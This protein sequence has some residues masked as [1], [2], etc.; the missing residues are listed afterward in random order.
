MQC[1]P[2][3]QARVFEVER[4][5]RDP[6]CASGLTMGL[7]TARVAMHISG[8]DPVTLWISSQFFARTT[9]SL[10]ELACTLRNQRGA[11]QWAYTEDPS[12]ADLVFVDADHPSMEA[13][14]ANV[15]A[16]DS[17]T[18]RCSREVSTDLERGLL[19]KPLRTARIVEVM[20]HREAALLSTRAA[21]SGAE[22]VPSHPEATGGAGSQAALERLGHLRVSRNGGGDD[23]VPRTLH[24]LEWGDGSAASILEL[25]WGSA[26]VS[27]DRATLNVWGDLQTLQALLLSPATQVTLRSQGAATGASSGVNGAGVVTNA[28][29]RGSMGRPHDRLPRDRTVRLR[30]WPQQPELVATRDRIAA[31]QRL[32]R[33][34]ILEEIL[35]GV[36]KETATWELE[37]LVGVLNACWQLGYLEAAEASRPAG[38]QPATRSRTSAP[39]AEGLFGRI[40]QRLGL[41]NP[42]THRP[43]PPNRPRQATES[44]ANRSR[45]SPV[46]MGPAEVSSGNPL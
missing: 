44:Q 25:R 37:C 22:A 46:S 1:P 28:Y 15:R 23:R 30:Q 41:G 14:P 36:R 18:I 39:S 9:G 10:L 11:A 32:R 45:R 3:R 6:G 40:R 19:G 20:A 33:G 24:V 2:N 43:E 31:L 4:A 21:R 38:A 34:L 5:R 16:P 12:Q 35:S 42:K 27:L 13:L 7:N 17:G 8:G 26:H 29:L